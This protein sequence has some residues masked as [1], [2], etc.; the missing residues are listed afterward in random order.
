MADKNPKNALINYFTILTKFRNNYKKINKSESYL[1]SLINIKLDNPIKNINFYHYISEA[2][3]LSI[4]F[5][6]KQK[7]LKDLEN[8]ISEN[9]KITEFL[10]KNFN[11]ILFDIKDIEINEQFF[12]DTLEIL[13][14]TDKLDDQVVK[15]TQ[16]KLSQLFLRKMNIARKEILEQEYCSE[17]NRKQFEDIIYL[18][19]LNGINLTLNELDP[20]EDDKNSKLLLNVFLE[21]NKN[22]DRQIDLKTYI[23]EVNRKRKNIEGSKDIAVLNPEI[24]F[25]NFAQY[26]L[27]DLINNLETFLLNNTNIDTL[28]V[29]KMRKKVGQY[30]QNVTSIVSYIEDSSELNLVVGYLYKIS[31]IFFGGRVSATTVWTYNTL[32]KWIT[33]VPEGLSLVNKIAL[34]RYIGNTYRFITRDVVGNITAKAFM[35]SFNVANWG[36]DKITNFITNASDILSNVIKPVCDYADDN[37]FFEIIHKDDLIQIKLKY[38]VI[39]RDTIT[40]LIN[41]LIRN[42]YNLYNNTYYLAIQGR[43]YFMSKY[44]RFLC[45]GDNKQNIEMAKSQ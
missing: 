13:L 30:K 21:L 1:Q 22:K 9:K 43:E 39:A 44:K 32:K 4:L 12:I 34:P 20:R 2:W 19:L 17:L 10:G 29:D 36:K 42:F 5:G 15:I 18:T 33:I 23:S 11:D 6:L 25:Y 3:I 14:G 38:N 45:E 24:T 40:N 7:F 16:M 27:S 8:E 26:E 37:S 31:D 41:L 28:T 35:L